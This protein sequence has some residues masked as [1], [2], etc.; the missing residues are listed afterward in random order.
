MKPSG[1]TGAI[2][3]AWVRE[4]IHQAECGWPGMVLAAALAVTVLG[5]LALG[6]MLWMADAPVYYARP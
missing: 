5:T 4:R 6:A 3:P 2:V 1:V